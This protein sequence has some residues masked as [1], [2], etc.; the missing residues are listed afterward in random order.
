M[1]KYNCIIIEDE[2]LATEILVEYVSQV[3]FLTLKG[4]YPNAIAALENMDADH[5]DLIFLDINLPRLKGFDFI[6]TL[7]NPPHIII[8]TAYQEFALQGYE[9]DV[10]DYLLKPIEFSRFLK[11]VNKVKMLGTRKEPAPPMQQPAG[12]DFFFVRTSKKMVKVYYRDILYIESFKEY[13]KIYTTGQVIVS[14]NQV[15]AFEESLPKGE[16]IRIHRSFIVSRDKI[17]AFTA[18]EIQ[19]ANK[20]L[21][22]GR[23]YKETVT[24]LLESMSHN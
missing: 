2:P 21:P 18:T 19:V 14:R 20:Q 4:T 24:H 22:I 12:N 16:F 11:A 23:S 13:I 5:I 17:Q 15:S 6:K 9:M 8:T 7:K 10:V 3:P 1:E